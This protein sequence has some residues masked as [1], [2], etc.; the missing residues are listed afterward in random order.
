MALFSRSQD[1]RKSRKLAV[2]RLNYMKT[3][4]TSNV[5]D[6]A[7]F[8]IRAPWAQISRNSLERRPRL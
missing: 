2:K 8:R 1:L 3:A 7:L 6:I 5:T 4:S